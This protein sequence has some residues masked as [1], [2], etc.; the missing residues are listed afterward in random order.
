MDEK[1]VV[2]QKQMNGWCPEFRYAY[3]SV[4]YNWDEIKACKNQ[5]AADP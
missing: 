5:A 4:V 2:C 3:D 1:L